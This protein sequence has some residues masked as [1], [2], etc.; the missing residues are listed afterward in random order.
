[1]LLNLF[2]YRFYL[3]LLQGLYDFFEQSYPDKINQPPEI[4]GQYNQCI[5]AVDLV[6][7]KGQNKGQALN[8]H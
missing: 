6:L 8:I 2:A 5:F 1:M 4:V 3:S 7:N